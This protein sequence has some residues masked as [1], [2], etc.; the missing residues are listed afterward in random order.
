MS[1]TANVFTR[2]EPEIK[3]QAEKILDQMGIPLSDAVS[4]FLHQIV[5]Q[6][7][8]PFEIKMPDAAPLATSS[9]NQ[10]QFNAEVAKGMKDMKAGRIYSSETIR[11]QMREDYGV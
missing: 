6:K 5:L 8:I 9:L 4:M 1:K 7:G 10:E 2:V 11:E 3:M